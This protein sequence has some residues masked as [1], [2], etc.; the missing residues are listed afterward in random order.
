[1]TKIKAHKRLQCHPLPPALSQCQV[2][3]T[4][5]P[6]PHLHTQL[7]CSQGS[8]LVQDP[9]TV[10]RGCILDTPTPQAPT[11]TTLACLVAPVPVWG[12]LHTRWPTRHLGTW[13][14]RCDPATHRTARHQTTKQDRAWSQAGCPSQAIPQPNIQDPPC[15]TWDMTQDIW[16]LTCNK[17]HTTCPLAA[18][19]RAGCLALQALAR[20]TSIQA[21]RLC[22][23]A[24]TQG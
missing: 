8:H 16:R 24:R 4:N 7:A 15:L 2:R 23:T 10:S 1:M 22:S 12:P 3:P 19:T 14:S 11:L 9:L 20:L 21:S 17:H 18:W 5:L 13:A 6:Q